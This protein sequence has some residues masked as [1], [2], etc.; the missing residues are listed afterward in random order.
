MILLLMNKLINSKIHILVYAGCVLFSLTASGQ[1]ISVRNIK[2][3]NL[4]NAKFYFEVSNP[5]DFGKFYS[6]SLELYS[7]DSN[8][9]EIKYDVFNY[10]AS[11]TTRLFE[12]AGNAITHHSFY[13]KKLLG[14]VCKRC[15]FR[16]R[17]DSGNAITDIKLKLYS[18][19]FIFY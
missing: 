1:S 19:S 16:L 4:F 15:K 8:W 3:E 6:V 9:H 13:P 7:K 2:P 11:K 17:V 12:I 5:S 14:S 10:T 18:E